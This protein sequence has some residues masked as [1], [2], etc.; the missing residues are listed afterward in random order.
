M[1]LTDFKVLTFDCYGTLIDWE[2]GI[3]AGLQ[4][5]TARVRRPVTRDEILAM[6]GR[7]EA[8]Q[9]LET[10]AMR[11]SELLARVHERMAA[12]WQV[13]TTRDEARAYGRSVPQWPAFPDTPDALRYLQRHYK[14]VILSNTDHESFV[15]SNE[16]LGVRF[17]AVFLAEDIG[18]YKPCDR[19]FEVMLAGLAQIG[20]ARGEILHTAESLYHD[21][22]P[23]NRHGLA[24]AWIHRRHAEQGYGATRDPDHPPHVDFRF[25]SMAAMV[26]AHRRELA[27]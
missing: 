2:R 13:T 27:A 3:L 20:V 17:D 15:G 25:T 8:A 12:E 16:H 22:I 6:H 4:P 5:L 24:S 23:A 19:N 10:P 18:S 21:H 14:L 1:R 11:Y 7:H 9:Q 26:D